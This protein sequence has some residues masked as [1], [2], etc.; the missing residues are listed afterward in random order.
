MPS[1]TVEYRDRIPRGSD[2][3]E[4]LTDAKHLAATAIEAVSAREAVAQA[5]RGLPEGSE[6]EVFFV[7]DEAGGIDVFWPDAEPVSFE[8]RDVEAREADCVI[9][10]T[11]QCEV[12]GVA[13]GTALF[14]VDTSEQLAPSWVCEAC[15]FLVERLV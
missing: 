3:P 1:F 7:P 12:H 6:P 8:R 9:R 11:E 13:E 5:A 10:V 4:H 2:T 14:V 15:A